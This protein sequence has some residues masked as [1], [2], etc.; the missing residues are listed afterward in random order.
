MG[1]KILSIDQSYTHCAFCIIDE[2]KLVDFGVFE[3]DKADS[4]YDRAL[5]IANKIIAVQQQHLPNEIRLE[6]LAFAMRGNATRDLAGLLF[7]IITTIK[8]K[9]QFN[10]FKIISPKTVKKTATGSGKATKKQMVNSLPEEIKDIFT[11]QGYK[12]TTG[13]TDL[14]DAFWIGKCE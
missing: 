10:N 5:Y 1:M 3:S 12:L 7:T 9:C 14:A 11:S 6:G 4:V 8:S 2:N 13:L